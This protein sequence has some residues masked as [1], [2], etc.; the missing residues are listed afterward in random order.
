MK[1]RLLLA[2]APA[3]GFSFAAKLGQAQPTPKLMV[4]SS[5]STTGTYYR[6]MKEFDEASPGLIINTGSD[7]SLTN[8]DRVMGNQAELGITQLDA[9][10]FRSLKETN[11]KERIRILALLYPEEIHFIA[12]SAPRTEGGIGAFGINTGIAS[13]SVYLNTIDDLRGR[14]IGCWGGAIITEQIIA[15]MALTGWAPV[16]YSDENLAL[17][18]LKNDQVDALMAIG[19]QPLGWVSD[20]PRDYRL[21]SV[22]DSAVARLASVYDKTTLT[23]RNLGQDGVQTLAVQAILVTRNYTS[24]SKRDQ[25]QM[26]H[27]KLV[28]AVADIRETRGTHPKWGDINPMAATDKWPMY[29]STKQ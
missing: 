7:G 25:L 8:I 3:L 22:S 2:A 15:S 13:R 21:L 9:L 6:L 17:E 10:F 28:D 29:L 27:D 19:G 26:L 24:K 5:G 18:A 12:K 23:Y 14:K 11:L 16:E 20:L 1:R 4:V